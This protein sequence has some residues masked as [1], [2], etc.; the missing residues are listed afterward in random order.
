MSGQDITMLF[1]RTNDDF[2]E[3]QGKNAKYATSPLCPTKDPSGTST[4]P[5]C[6]LPQLNEQT[7]E[8]LKLKNLTLW[9]GY[10]W[11]QVAELD[12][13]LVL[14][15]YVLNMGPYLAAN[16][17]AIDDDPVDQVIR[18]ALDKQ[19]GSGK[20]VT[21][22]FYHS[23]ELRDAIPCMTSRY[24]A[25][26]ID[27]MTP[28]CF[29][30][31]L[32]LYCS[33]GVILGVVLIRFFMALI[34]NWFI[35]HRLVEKQ[36]VHGRAIAPT[37][38]P[39]G[40]NVSVNNQ[41]GTAP[42]AS[43]GQKS[44][45]A[46][47]MDMAQIG[48]DLFT[49]CLI[50]CYSEGEEGIRGTL[51]SIAS[52]T[53]PDQ[54]KLLWIVC[55][56]M[57]TGAG[58]KMST[59]DIC[60]SM[61]DADPRFGNPQPMGYI[62][63]GSGSKKENRAMVY[64]GHYLT[65]N[66]HRTPA[67][68]VVKCGMPSEAN[69]AKPGN[70]GKRDSQLILMNFFSR[71]TYND[72]MTPLDYDLFRKV[73]TLMGVTPDFFELC[74]MVDADTKVYPDSLT[75]LVHC[76]A[77]DN[78]IMGVC[79]ETRIA[80][81]RQSWVTAIQVFEY[82]ISHHHIKAF[83]SVFGGVTCLPGC[84]S[85]YRIKARKDDDDDWVPIL[86]KPEIVRE[87]SQSD[88]VTLHQKNL[89]LLGEDRF[90]STIMLRT[91]PHR[92]NIFLPQARCRTIAP[93]E[94]KVLLSQRRRWINS[95]I[96]NLMELVLVRDLCGT[97]CFSM[98]FVVFMDLVGTIVLPIAICLTGALIINSIIK[99]PTD[100]V[101]A[102]PLMLLACILGLP[103]VLITLTTRKMIY[104]AWM[105]VYLC[106]LPVWNF[107]LPVY[108]FWH[109]DDFSWGETR[110]VEGEVVD[111]AGHGGDKAIFD[112]TT[113]PLRR[114]EDWERSR[115]RKLRREEKR[116]KQM[117]RAHGQGFYN[118]DPDALAIPRNMSRAA[119][120]DDS[121]S[122]MSSEEDVWGAEIGGYNENHP[123]YPPPP[124]ALAPNAVSARP[125]TQVLGM[126]EM[127]AL[128]DQGFDEPPAAAWRP[129]RNESSPLHR[130]P[131]QPADYTR[132]PKASPPNDYRPLSPRSP[133]GTPTAGASTGV[134]LQDHGATSTSIESGQHQGQH[135]RQRSKTYGPLG[136]LDDYGH[137]R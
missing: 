45:P 95:T 97:F 28:G 117:E 106:A 34:F 2:P 15:G 10:S 128:L 50:T 83:E 9:E 100:F 94:F 82:Y 91:F 3:C 77:N 134:Q 102:I 105:L 23:Q 124:M 115:L 44:A 92:R 33:L 89:L 20:D 39:E 8:T 1:Q 37:V 65:K 47:I 131:A 79:G 27:K 119:L 24:L 133:G 116:R 121:G 56:G 40:A 32:F 130:H 96:H 75:H 67:V 90:L 29:V 86:V 74:L 85:M 46:P 76:M 93:D 14:D 69:D 35:A 48:Q 81:K 18:R 36:D 80:N 11:E 17:N 12:D 68:I 5:I 109:F 110:K 126:D 127:A 78:R 22:Q 84:F 57:I 30:A 54:R 114:W 107:V 51:D 125:G 25:G 7:V 113:I 55:D 104:V 13:Y 137:G 70:R 49:V 42:W 108:S 112:G 60:V 111:K 59:P 120:S 61:L 4:D 64:A 19:R 72:R 63:V 26:H 58:E 53:F 71:C 122:I 73:Q 6:S 99:P 101:E 132:T 62:A 103:A 31:A 123:A 43:G 21:N 52:T 118:D 136:P 87:Y 66:G 98:Q 38:M 16:P 41:N 129:E 88:V 135:A